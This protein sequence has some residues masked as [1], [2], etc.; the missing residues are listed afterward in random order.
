MG[1]AALDKSQRIRTGK[2]YLY[3][4]GRGG[5]WDWT[6]VAGGLCDGSLW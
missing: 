5:S 4:A 1:Q 6:Q 3:T 2:F